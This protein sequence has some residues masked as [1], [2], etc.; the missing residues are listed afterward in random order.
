MIFPPLRDISSSSPR[1]DSLYGIPGTSPRSLKNG[2]GDLSP[3][4][5]GFTYDLIPFPFARPS[6]SVDV[7]VP[8]VGYDSSISTVLHSSVTNY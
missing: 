7:D 8:V 6:H 5:V 1:D 2:R 4:F 3:S